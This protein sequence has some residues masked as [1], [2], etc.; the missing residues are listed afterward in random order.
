MEPNKKLSPTVLL[1]CFSEEDN[2][3]FHF[4]ISQSYFKVPNT[5]RLN[6]THLFKKIPNKREI[7]QIASNHLSDIHFKDLMKFY[8]DYT[9]EPYTFLVNDTTL[10][11]G[12]PLR[13]RKNLLQKW[14][15]NEWV[16]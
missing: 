14:V 1:N 16:R 10:P 2:S 6:A 5:I 11:S 7:Q 4:F 8:K 13:F 9:K 15:L 12:N 3:R